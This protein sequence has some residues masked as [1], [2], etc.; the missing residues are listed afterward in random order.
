MKRSIPA[1]VLAL[2]TVLATGRLRPRRQGRRVCPA[3]G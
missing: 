3:D 1:L 2:A